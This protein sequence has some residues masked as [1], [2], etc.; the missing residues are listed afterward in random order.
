MSKDTEMRIV[1]WILTIMGYLWAYSGV[2]KIAAAAMNGGPFA[3]QFIFTG[4]GTLIVAALAL[5]G[6][7]KLRDKADARAW[8]AEKT[9]KG[10]GA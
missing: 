2:V 5:W 10:S 8:E 3:Q 9:K 6:G 4:L 1:G 7:S